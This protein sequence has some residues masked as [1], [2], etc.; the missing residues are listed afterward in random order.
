MQACEHR[1]P[2]EVLR[3][4]HQRLDEAVILHWHL[5]RAQQGQRMAALL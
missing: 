1:P 5:F 4:Q 2:A 3:L